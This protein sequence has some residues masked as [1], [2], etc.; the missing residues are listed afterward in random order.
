MGECGL[1][2]NKCYAFYRFTLP[3]VFL[4]ADKPNDETPTKYKFDLIS[5]ELGLENEN[6]EVL[7]ESIWKIVEGI[8][9]D[10]TDTTFSLQSIKTDTTYVK[11]T[12]RNQ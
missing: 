5:S 12:M 4:S 11:T 9:D 2:L 3:D 7:Q 1:I 10:D 8:N 6:P